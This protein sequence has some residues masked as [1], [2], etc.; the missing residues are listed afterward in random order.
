VNA[1]IQLATVG[2]S[3][4]YAHGKQTADAAGRYELDNLPVGARIYFQVW[5]EDHAQQCA[6][7]PLISDRDLS[8]DA[9]LVA[10]AHI[11]SSPDA[12]PPSPPG[13]RLVSGVVYEVIADG[14]RPASNVFVDYEP[15][16]DFPAAVTYTDAEGRFLLCGIPSAESASIGAGQGFRV[17][18]REVPPGP[19][20]TIEIEIR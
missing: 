8:L 9:Q 20:A 3:Y 11:S 17:G 12:V 14:R 6:S 10:R 15:V 7:P 19:D 13:L 16:S 5:K 2:Y 4:W 18:Y 1:W